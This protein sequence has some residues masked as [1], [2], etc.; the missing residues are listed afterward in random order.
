M[1]N[2]ISIITVAKTTPKRENQL[3]NQS[4]KCKTLIWVFKLVYLLLSSDWARETKQHLFLI[5]DSDI[6]ACGHS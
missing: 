6:F 3:T 5:V 4:V 1:N 2:S